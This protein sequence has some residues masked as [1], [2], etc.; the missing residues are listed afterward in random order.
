MIDEPVIQKDGKLQNAIMCD[1][2]GTLA[3]NDHGRK[4]WG[5]ET[6]LCDKDSLNF[7]VSSVLQTY[8]SYNRSILK[9]LAD[10]DDKHQ[11]DEFLLTVKIIYMSGREDKYKPSTVKFLKKHNLDSEVWTELHMRKTD[12]FREDSIIKK[13]L[14]DAHVKDKYDV[15]FVLDD[16]DQVVNMWRNELGLACFQV[17]NGNF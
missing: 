6:A 2:D 5:E 3:I 9:S 14:Y 17:A 10:V 11:V 1:L 15:L 13:E 8:M 7:P 16:R 12:D 4:F